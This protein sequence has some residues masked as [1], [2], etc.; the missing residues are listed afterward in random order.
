MEASQTRYLA[1]CLIGITNEPSEIVILY[2]VININMEMEGMFDVISGRIYV[3]LR[4]L[5]WFS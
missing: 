4:M 5:S 3:V 2:V 1:S